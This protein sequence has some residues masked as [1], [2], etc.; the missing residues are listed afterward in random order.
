MEKGYHSEAKRSL[1][2]NFLVSET[3]ARRIV[4]ALSP[5]VGELVLEIGPGRGAL[6]VPLAESGVSVVAYEIDRSLVEHLRVKCGTLENVEIVHA[7]VR[8]VV[9]DDEA[10][11]RRKEHYGVI[12]NIPYHLT[13]TILSGLA[14]L[15][16]CRGSVLMVQR[17]VGE[18]ILASPGSRSCGILS[19]FLQGYFK[20][21]RVIKVRPGS[22]N[23]RPKVESVVLKFTPEEPAGAPSDRR[24]FLNFLKIAFSQ[25]RKKLH[26]S[27]RG[28]GGLRS[29]GDLRRAVEMSGVEL[30][31]RPE[32]LRLDDWFRLFTVLNGMMRPE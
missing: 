27:L 22:F 9:F 24:G 26:G 1:G 3:V 29:A 32:E 10:G 13:G 11:I 25:R 5:A 28:Y 21:E 15:Q 17:E 8:N 2:Q 30:D 14:F 6:T 16:K 12:G 7:D 4:D 23:P 31:R 20:V 18:R 19:V